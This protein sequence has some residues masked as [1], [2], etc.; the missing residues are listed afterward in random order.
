M[1][2]QSSGRRLTVVDQGGKSHERGLLVSTRQAH[3]FDQALGHKRGQVD[4][5]LIALPI[6]RSLTA[7]EESFLLEDATAT[8]SRN[9]AAIS[10]KRSV[11]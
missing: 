11:A 3:H 1:D 10:P 4:Q 5:D 9:D 2:G 6:S 8:C 7:D